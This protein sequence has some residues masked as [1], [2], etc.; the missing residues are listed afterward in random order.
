MRLRYARAVG[1]RKFCVYIEAGTEWDYIGSV[2]MLEDGSGWAGIFHAKEGAA[3]EA[4]SRREVAEMLADAW[5]K[6]QG[7]ESTPCL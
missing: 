6:R 5:K 4:P 7:A 2:W 3:A 1:F